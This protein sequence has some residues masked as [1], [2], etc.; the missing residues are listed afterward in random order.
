M[1]YEKGVRSDEDR[2]DYRPETDRSIPIGTR[3]SKAPERVI[4]LER[5]QA[6][7]RKRW[8]IRPVPPVAPLSH[9]AGYRNVAPLSP[10]WLQSCTDRFPALCPAGEKS[11]STFSGNK[12]TAWEEDSAVADGGDHEYFITSGPIAWSLRQRLARS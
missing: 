2:D 12:E 9:S 3:T 10:A 4:V 6:Q 7:V 5:L 11:P 1:A 8:L